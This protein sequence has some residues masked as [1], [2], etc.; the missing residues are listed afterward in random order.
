M[1][2]ESWL[3]T[4][5]NEE[6]IFLNEGSFDHSPAILNVYP[7]L[8]TGKKPFKYFNMWK[9]HPKYHI[10]VGSTWRQQV[11]GTRMY[12]VV[13]KLKRLKNVFKEINKDARRKFSEVN[14]AYCS[15]L[16][17]KAKVIWL[18]EGDANTRLFHQSLKQRRSQNRVFSIENKEG[19]RVD[20]PEDV[21]KA[22]ISF[23]EHLLGSK[24]GNRKL[25][26]QQ[27]VKQGPMLTTAHIQLLEKEYKTEEV[28]AAAFSIPSIK[29]P[30]PDGY[31]SAFY[32]ENWE[33]IGEDIGKAVLSFLHSGAILKEIN[34]TVL[35]LIPKVKC[36]NTEEEIHRVL[37]MSGFSRQSIPFR[38][39]GY[40][41]VQRESQQKNVMGL[42]RKW[43]FLWNQGV[44]DR[45]GNV[46]WDSLWGYNMLQP[47]SEKKK[48]SIDRSDEGMALLEHQCN[49]S[50]GDFKENREGE[51]LKNQKAGVECNSCS[52]GVCPMDYPK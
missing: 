23:Y 51:A 18:N 34:S 8:V 30:G 10:M 48:W 29:A 38:Y 42:C 16:Q 9:T 33:L 2:N 1:A 26:K 24:M 22:F 37:N 45:A 6:V 11:E 32:Q 52:A 50:F 3:D 13:T 28:K 39:L 36:P 19:E 43:N 21:T 40:P 41:F 7:N 20:N 46:A 14:K 27:V 17:Q 4:F 47:V 5:L 31:G 44:A 35:T 49:I 15:F 25:V 12:Q